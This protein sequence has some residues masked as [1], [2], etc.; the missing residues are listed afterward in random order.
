MSKVI[1]IKDETQLDQIISENENVL[2]DFF[3]KW[4]QPCKNLL[5]VLDELSNE[6][7]NIVICKVD[8]DITPEIAKKNNIVS[9]PTLIFYKGGD[10][11]NKTKGFFN[12]KQLKQMFENNF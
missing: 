11:V 5:P 3:A 10:V 12:I 1:L 6:V 8:V 9:I 2:I 4:C 7:T